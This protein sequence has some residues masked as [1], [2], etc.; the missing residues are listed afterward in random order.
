MKQAKKILSQNGQPMLSA[1]AVATTL[2]CAPDYIGK[3]CRD[4]KLE[5]AQLNGAWFVYEQSV[6]LFVKARLLQK[7]NRS[8]ELSVLR[9]QELSSNSFIPKIILNVAITSAVI[10]FV[11]VASVSF[12]KMLQAVRP[13]PLGAALGQIQSPFFA[14]QNFNLQLSFPSI[15]GQMFDQLFASHIQVE[16]DKQNLAVQKPIP[17]PF[18]TTT[19]AVVKPV[20]TD[21]NVAAVAMPAAS[22]REQYA[23][24]P[25]VE[26]TVERVIVENGISPELLTSIVRELA[27][28]KNGAIQYNNNGSF[29][30][31]STALTWDNKAGKFVVEGSLQA[32]VLCIENVCLTKKQL[33]DLLDKNAI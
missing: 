32:Q 15:F 18:S 4:G 22:T 24:Y 2:D 25:V 5:G 29:S 14:Q 6:L 10:G 17:D 21:T 3:L 8:K 33:Q 23:I 19:V 26:R 27:A 13:E 28:G 9:K 7:E 30:A 11:F 16:V 20:V 1:R 12:T 31:S